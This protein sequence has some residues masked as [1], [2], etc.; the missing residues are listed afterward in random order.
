MFR[1]LSGSIRVA[2]R[3]SALR[4]SLLE[5]FCMGFYKRFSARDSGGSW[6]LGFTAFWGLGFRV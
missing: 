1:G 5:G 2:I 6:V 3:L 4:L